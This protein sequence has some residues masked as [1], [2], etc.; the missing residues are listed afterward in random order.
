MLGRAFGLEFVEMSL[1]VFVNQWNTLHRKFLLVLNN[2]AS[3]TDCCVT[4]TWEVSCSNLG[5]LLSYFDSGS[6]EQ[7][8]IPF[9]TAIVLINTIFSYIY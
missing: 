6:N 7:I 2:S 4:V 3:R 1:V 8:K 9:S 5:F